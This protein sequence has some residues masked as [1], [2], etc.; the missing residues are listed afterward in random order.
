M[1]S[2]ESFP[3]GMTFNNDG[4]KMY[5]IGSNGDEI[6]EYSLTIAFDIST[7]SHVHRFFQ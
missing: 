7:A 5:V 1:N 4:T 2:Q 6:N 3:Q